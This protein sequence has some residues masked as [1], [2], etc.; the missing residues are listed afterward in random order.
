MKWCELLGAAGTSRAK[1]DTQRGRASDSPSFLLGSC[2]DREI[3]TVELGQ[4]LAPI[5]IAVLVTSSIIRCQGWFESPPPASV[6]FPDSLASHTL[7]GRPSQD[8]QTWI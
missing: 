3:E 5:L 1:R 8:E 4:R 7:D 2:E 6:I